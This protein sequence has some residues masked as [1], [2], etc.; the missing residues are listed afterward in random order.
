M[1]FSIDKKIIILI[2]IFILIICIYYW[3]SYES[4][5][6]DE[7]SHYKEAM[8][9]NCD[10]NTKI[11][12]QLQQLNNKRCN[13]KGKTDRDT[14][15][16]KTVCYDDT[17]KEIVSGLDAESYC[18]MAKYIPDSNINSK[19]KPN[20][21]DDLKEGPDFINTFTIQPS[22]T[23]E[24]EQFANANFVKIDNVSLPQNYSDVSKLSSDTNFLKELM[25]N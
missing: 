3:S 18:K 17:G 14:I 10:N 22:E 9:I 15:N 23:V 20:L 4:F 1:Q 16:N 5:T 19:I 12:E 25:H 13:D 8:Q 11:H 21:V 6:A 2:V 24:Q 7:M